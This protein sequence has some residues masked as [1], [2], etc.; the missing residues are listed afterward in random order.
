MDQ[1]MPLFVWKLT[2]G[3]IVTITIVVWKL[4]FGNRGLAYFGSSSTCIMFLRE[5][6]L[7]V[8]DC[9]PN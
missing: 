2:F 3:T 7:G 6:G 4:T 1:L 8:H 5:A 9:W